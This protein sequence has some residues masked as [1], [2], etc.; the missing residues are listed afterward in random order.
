M[1]QLNT[2]HNYTHPRTIDKVDTIAHVMHI[3]T[4]YTRL[5]LGIAICNDTWAVINGQSTKAIYSSRVIAAKRQQVA[6]SY[7]EDITSFNN[8]LAEIIL[9]NQEKIVL[10][11]WEDIYQH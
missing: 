5:I 2:Y 4:K 6:R 1:I 3:I 7:V 8:Q 11:C 10:Q 9:F